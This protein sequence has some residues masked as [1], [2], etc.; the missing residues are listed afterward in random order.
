MS[1]GPKIELSRLREIGW[2]IWDPIG[3]GVENRPDDEYDS[4]LLE[5]AVRLRNGDSDDAVADF[6]VH[7][8]ADHMDLGRSA[9]ATERALRCVRALRAYLEEP[10]AEGTVT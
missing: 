6:L 5:A 10:G 2:A 9:Q 8:E 3:L 7:I 1:I 4:Y